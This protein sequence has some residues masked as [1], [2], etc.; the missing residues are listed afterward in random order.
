MKHLQKLLDFMSYTNR[1][2]KQT[3]R[4]IEKKKNYLSMNDDDFLFEYI[5]I[6]AKHKHK[7]FI[8]TVITITIL[9]AIIMDIWRKLYDFI[10]SLPLSKKVMQSLIVGILIICLLIVYGFIRS[11]YRVTKDKVLI[12]EVKILR[13]ENT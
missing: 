13:N 9:I 2:N 12:D 7:R 8:L 10:F 5:N 6:S 4:L 3:T 11:L 1:K